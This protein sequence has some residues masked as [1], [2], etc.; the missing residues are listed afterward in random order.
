MLLSMT[1][2]E[3]EIRQ[4]PDCMRPSDVE[5]IQGDC[6]KFR[7]QT[8]SNQTISFDKAME[9]LLNYWRERVRCNFSIIT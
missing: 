2:K 5:V 7:K 6:P 3:I 1:D 4:D 8:S 9:D